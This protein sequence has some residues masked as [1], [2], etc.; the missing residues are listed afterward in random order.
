MLDDRRY[1][2]YEHRPLSEEV[3]T[4]IAPS[5]DR[6][7]ETF[8]GNERHISPARAMKTHV[9]LLTSVSPPNAVSMASAD[10]TREGAMIGDHRPSV[11]SSIPIVVDNQIIRAFLPHPLGRL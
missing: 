6:P 4:G 1:P 7:Q 9:P 8:L 10:P 3:H 11:T 2:D 5:Q